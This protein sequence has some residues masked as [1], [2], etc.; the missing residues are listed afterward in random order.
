MSSAADPSQAGSRCFLLDL[1]SLGAANVLGKLLW[2][3]S[4][5]MA[6][7]LLGAQAYGELVVIWSV[8]ALLAPQTDLGFSQL[9]LREGAREREFIPPLLRR[10]LLARAV[11]GI[12]VVA[13]LAVGAG[14]TSFTALPPLIVALAAAGPLVDAVFLT[15][16]PLAQAEGRLRLYCFWRVAS[17][18]LMPLLLLAAW[19]LGA[20]VAGVAGGWVAASVFGLAGFFIGRGR[21]PGL[22]PARSLPWRPTLARSLP[23][24]LMGTVALSYGKL[25][26]V[27]LG[28]VA[29]PSQAALYHAAYQVLLLVFSASD[30]FFAALFAGLYRAHAAPDRLGLVWPQISRVLA[31]LAALAFPVL[32]WHGESLMRLI[33]GEDFALAG[34]VLRGLLPMILLLPLGAALNFLTL[35]DRP[36]WRA[37]LDFACVLATAMAALFFAARL[38]AS[39]LAWIASS[40]YGLT[41]LL[42]WMAARS[43]GLRLP[44][45]RDT[46][47]ALLSVSLALPVFWLAWPWWSTALLFASAGI[48]LLVLFGRLGLQDLGRLADPDG[49]A[50]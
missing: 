1:G 19:T 2:A 23:F 4:L 18:A 36:G 20:G 8:A 11:L 35:L 45:M 21:P 50:K 31:A 49:D 44:W 41:C 26:V 33:G 38:Q 25:E 48:G 30:I 10:A 39:G 32:W 14:T 3:I 46:A 43:L 29:D 37:A 24:L 28:T 15:A 9:L 40:I 42:A 47:L 17:F 7:R 13:A 16:T 5:A 34:S 22:M 12:A 27:V 6:M